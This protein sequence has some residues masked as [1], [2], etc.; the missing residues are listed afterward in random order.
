MSKPIKK[1]SFFTLPVNL[2][3]I[4]FALFAAYS[5]YW[6]WMSGEIYK[7]AQNWV[8]EQRRAG[9]EIAYSEVT[10]TGWPY[11]FV[12]DIRSPEI[13]AAHNQI[14]WSGERLE[15]VAMSWN[16]FHIIAQ[17]PGQNMITAPDGQT[18]SFV[19]D[20][21]TA[22]S[23]KLNGAN[24]ERFVLTVPAAEGQTGDGT[25]FSLVN[26]S[27]GLRP[28]PETDTT[29][30]L[31]VS[32]EDLFL[33]APPANAEW[34]GQNIHH[35]VVWLEVENFYPLARGEMTPV[36]WKIDRNRL[37]LRRGE[38]KWGPLDIA[39]RAS[40]TLDR[41]N[42]PDGTL[43]IHLERSDDLLTALQ[44][45]GQLTRETSALINTVSLLS[46]NDSFATV[47]V[48]ERGIYYLNNRLAGY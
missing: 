4:A 29:L 22:A 16:L 31:V 6:F 18:Y 44:T 15:L 12:L 7:G 38:I 43:G 36:D 41:D 10:V 20:K 48:K 28:L 34:L 39:T 47:K 8:K 21:K 45:A 25:P 23:L 32:I 46:K 17:V 9:Y 30:Q 13:R 37:E 14:S 3:L 40:V 19:P 27:I 1:A 42:N 5:A 26:L 2:V 11:R 33:P 35:L 24:P